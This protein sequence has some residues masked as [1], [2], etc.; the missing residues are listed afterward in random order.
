MPEVQGEVV[1][2]PML[3]S[4]QDATLRVRVLDVTEADAPA[5]PLAELALPALS[6]DGS[7]ERRVPFS[8]PSPAWDPRRTVIVTAHLDRSG[9]GEVEAGDALTTRAEPA[10]QDRLT[11]FLTP[12]RGS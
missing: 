12:I 6:Y 10:S 3:G 9:T 11:L 7:A 8:L 4:F 5:G 2:T 1:L